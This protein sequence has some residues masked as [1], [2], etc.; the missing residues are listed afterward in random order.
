MNYKEAHI[1]FPKP[2]GDTLSQYI[3]SEHLVLNQYVIQA[4][5]EKLEKDLKK[6]KELSP[7]AS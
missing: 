3:E 4:V 6:K 7:Q 5:R 1:R 2:L